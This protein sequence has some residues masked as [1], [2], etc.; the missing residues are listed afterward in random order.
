[1]LICISGL[2]SASQ[3]QL[4]SIPDPRTGTAAPFL[5][6]GPSYIQ[7]VSWFKEQYASWFSGDTVIQGVRPACLHTVGPALPRAPAAGG[8]QG[9][10][11]MLG[12]RATTNSCIHRCTWASHHT[13]VQSSCLVRQVKPHFLI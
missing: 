4:L 2:D 13:S 6:T 9:T 7:E 5:L 10:G 11:E 12:E 3:A 1:M 8:Q